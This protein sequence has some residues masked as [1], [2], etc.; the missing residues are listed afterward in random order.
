MKWEGGV[1]GGGG[2]VIRTSTSS[3]LRS[4]FVSESR[5]MMLW[6]VCIQRTDSFIL[7]T[8]RASGP[9]YLLS[10]RTPA[11]ALARERIHDRATVWAE[12]SEVQVT[13][14]QVFISCRQSHPPKAW[15]GLCC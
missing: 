14:F 4:A 7:A 11:S 9:E 3:F 12:H 5:G 1:E 10:S 13:V 15:Q 6:S 2:G 8:F